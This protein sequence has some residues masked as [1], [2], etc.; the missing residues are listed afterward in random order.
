MRLILAED[1][2]TTRAM[3]APLLKTW[4]YEVV[5]VPN[6]NEAWKILSAEESPCLALLDWMMPGMSGLEVCRKLRSL[7][8]EKPHFLIVLTA[9]NQ[10]DDVVEAFEAGADDFVVKPYNVQELKARVQV[11]KRIVELMASLSERERFKGALEMAGAVCHELNQP[12][13]SVSG[14]SELIMMELSEDHPLYGQLTHIKDGVARIADLTRKIM[15][16][17]R[18]QSKPYLSSGKIFDIEK[19]SKE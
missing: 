18:Y 2:D 5:A 13:Q 15:R 8:R 19:G 16:I 7:N 1:D 6:G 14:F 10:S 4:G 11:G 12:L 3:L 9:K 17:T